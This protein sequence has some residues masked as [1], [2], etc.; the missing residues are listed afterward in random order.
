MQ[1]STSWPC[2]ALATVVFLE[3]ARPSCCLFWGSVGTDP[4]PNP[5]GP[6]SHSYRGINLFR[7]SLRKSRKDRLWDATATA[8]LEFLTELTS[9]HTGLVDGLQKQK[10]TRWPGSDWLGSSTKHPGRWKLLML[11]QHHAYIY[12]GDL[13]RYTQMLQ[14]SR[15]SALAGAGDENEADD[16]PRG[17]RAPKQRADWSCCREYYRRAAQMCPKNGKPYNQLAVL[18]LYGE[19]PL[20]AVY[21]YSRSLAV[22]QPILTARDGLIALYEKI[23]K[24]R[25]AVEK[26]ACAIATAAAANSP[27]QAAA[28]DQR[29]S[30]WRWTLPEQLSKLRSAGAAKDNDVLTSCRPIPAAVVSG[31][32]LS[33]RERTKRFAAAFL[34]VHGVLF[35]KV[36]VDEMARLESA[37]LATL[38]GALAS[39]A[40][41]PQR[42]VQVL[43]VAIFEVHNAAGTWSG[44]GAGPD[45]EDGDAPHS[46]PDPPSLV[47][48]VSARLAF[49]TGWLILDHCADSLARLT[50]EDVEGGRGHFLTCL[51]ALGIFVDWMVSRPRIWSNGQAADGAQ[52]RFWQ[53]LCRCLNELSR[54]EPELQIPE[55]FD[56]WETLFDLDGSAPKA[57]DDGGGDED[58]EDDDGDAMTLLLAGRRGGSDDDGDD[59]DDYDDWSDSEE[60]GAESDDNSDSSGQ[61]AKGEEA[62]VDTLA[63]DV[64]VVEPPAVA[65]NLVPVIPPDIARAAQE[66]GLELWEDIEIRG[67]V[68]LEGA[69]SWREHQCAA[70]GRG[71]RSRAASAADDSPIQATKP[72]IKLALRLARIIALAGIPQAAAFVQFRY[73]D[74]TDILDFTA[75]ADGSV[76]AP[77][78]RGPASADRMVDAAAGAENV[79]DAPLP[80]AMADADAPV[81]PDAGDRDEELQSLQERRAQ[82]ETEMR[83]K[84]SDRADRDV[85]VRRVMELR[86]TAAKTARTV[87]PKVLF[88]DTNCF[89]DTLGL[90]VRLVE[91]G[92]FKVSIPMMVVNELYSLQKGSPDGE[93]AHK[94][95]LAEAARAAV[96]FLE[97]EFGKAQSV[98]TALTGAGSVLK[99][100]E[101]RS[102]TD[103][104]AEDAS[105]DDLILQSCVQFVN[106]HGGFDTTADGQVTCTVALLTGDINMKIKSHAA[107]IPVRTIRDFSRWAFQ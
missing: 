69:T 22:R 84:D 104:R 83:S 55:E 90:M 16:T 47:Y 98:V 95:G 45:A 41:S 2:A 52:P 102:E 42:L 63:A 88:P 67:F 34:D 21:F 94:K 100:I 99:T 103:T 31:E 57:D 73:D 4:A 3:R 24:K 28:A 13:E 58:E 86:D 17:R 25:K 93:H 62:V 44:D 64:T 75:V 61:A 11:N 101:F 107:D 7:D 9:A 85:E 72:Q 97:A 91:C 49:E 39:K 89:L 19:N 36:S 56:I 65:A 48:T 105:N 30:R 74:D 1:P 54:K 18:A 66:V 80:G 33:P 53:S 35:S 87:T 43:L 14:E 68:H 76:A 78:P 92:V 60:D 8:Y 15:S 79:R 40:L 70:A 96:A 23:R 50:A 77:D 5:I 12:L 37:S 81:S 27:T 59:Y 71:G 51:P 6:T 32:E 26:Q 38:D 29:D 46:N 20:E 10:A 82:L 106:K